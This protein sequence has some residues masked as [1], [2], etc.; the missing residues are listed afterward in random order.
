MSHVIG[1]KLHAP[2]FRRHESCR[3][4]VHRE[5]HGAEITQ[6]QGMHRL[7]GVRRRS[8]EGVEGCAHAQPEVAQILL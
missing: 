3:H 2:G 6:K 5:R 7:G 1:K 8:H 4:A